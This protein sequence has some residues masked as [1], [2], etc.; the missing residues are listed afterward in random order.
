M[1]WSGEGDRIIKIAT[2]TWSYNKFLIFIDWCTLRNCLPNTLICWFSSTEEASMVL[3]FPCIS[4]RVLNACYYTYK[5]VSSNVHS[6]GN[7]VVYYK[8][9]M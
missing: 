9:A 2:R 8:I 7:T 3:P 5:G 4:V 1:E 6:S